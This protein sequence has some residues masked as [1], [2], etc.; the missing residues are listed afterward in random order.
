M[1]AEAAPYWVSLEVFPAGSELLRQGGR[2]GT[3]FVLKSGEVEVLRD[4]ALIRSISQ[5]GAIFGEMSVLLDTPHTATVRTVSSVEAYRIDNA[6]A[7]LEA[8]PAWALQL[9][10]LL[11]QRLADT[12]AQLV[13]SQARES[14]VAQIIA[15]ASFV[16]MLGDPQI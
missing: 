14:S 10:R 1:T 2:L 13:T 11:A 3:I 6:V 16:R 5:P 9:A 12:T 4:M 8:R 7:M 15:P